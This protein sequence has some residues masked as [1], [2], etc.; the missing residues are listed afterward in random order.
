MY[1]CAVV[2]GVVVG[3]GVGA[4][5]VIQSAKTQVLHTFVALVN[6]NL[7]LIRL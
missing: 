4:G 7:R 5:G 3:V 6:A 1:T 2:V